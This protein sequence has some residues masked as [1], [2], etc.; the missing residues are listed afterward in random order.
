MCHAKGVLS[1]PLAEYQV[2]YPTDASGISDSAE[3]DIRLGGVGY[4]TRRNG[5]S[6][7]GRTASRLTCSLPD[8]YPEATDNLGNRFSPTFRPQ[9]LV[10]HDAQDCAIHQTESPYS[11]HRVR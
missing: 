11:N 8:Y 2:G 1:L 5:L 10:V 3:W 9:P 7:F 4:P 6:D